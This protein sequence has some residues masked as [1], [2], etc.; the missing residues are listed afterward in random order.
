MTHHVDKGKTT[1]EFITPSYILENMARARRQEALARVAAA[2]GVLAQQNAALERADRTA[3]NEMTSEGGL[4]NDK[5][6]GA[7]A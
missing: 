1:F 5:E 2:V 4:V 7:N 3:Q 6:Q